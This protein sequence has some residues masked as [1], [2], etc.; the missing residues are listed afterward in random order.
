MGRA[1]FVG[2]EREPVSGAVEKCGG[3]YAGAEGIDA[4]RQAIGGGRF[5]GRGSEQAEAVDRRAFANWEAKS[6]NSSV[7]VRHWSKTPDCQHYAR[8]FPNNQYL[9]LTLR[10]IVQ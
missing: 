1:G 6:L 7:E 4:R 3:R 2:G 8:Y 5:A 10:R 9:P